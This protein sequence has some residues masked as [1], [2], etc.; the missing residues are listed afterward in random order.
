MFE[1]DGPV[2]SFGDWLR[3][4]KALSHMESR[5][6]LPVAEVALDADPRG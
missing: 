6:T 2:S 5:N 4:E 3:A 1:A